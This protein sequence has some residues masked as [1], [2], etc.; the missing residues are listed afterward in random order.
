MAVLGKSSVTHSELAALTAKGT[1]WSPRA[2]GFACPPSAR[3]PFGISSSSTPTQA[4]FLMGDKSPKAKD[5]AR[6][7]DTA[8]KNQKK[9]NA[10]TKATAV[11][12]ANKK[13]K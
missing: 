12:A 7:Q 11:S 9:A 1:L 8:V 4:V 13:S 6:K 10:F 2:V 3:A 5:K